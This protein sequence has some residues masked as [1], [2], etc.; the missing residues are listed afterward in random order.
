MSHRLKVVFNRSAGLERVMSIQPLTDSLKEILGDQRQRVADLSSIP[1][2]VDP[3][4]EFSRLKQTVIDRIGDLNSIAI[5]TI[6][7]MRHKV[8]VLTA[9][10]TQVDVVDLAAYRNGAHVTFVIDP[11]TVSQKPTDVLEHVSGVFQRSKAL[12]ASAKS[13]NRDL[14]VTLIFFFLL[15]AIGV[16]GVVFPLMQQ[17]MGTD[18]AP[19][20]LVAMVW[21]TIIGSAIS[22][23]AGSAS[24]T[25]FQGRLQR[26][27]P[28]LNMLVVAALL[29]ILGRYI[30]VN[31]I[32]DFELFD[33]LSP[34]W[35]KAIR[36]LSNIGA[37]VALFC[38]EFGAGRCLAYAWMRQSQK[39]DLPVLQEIIG[40][41][42]AWHIARL[43][44]QQAES[45]STQAIN[46]TDV[47]KASARIL[48]DEVDK[49]LQPH[50]DIVGEVAR[51][52]DIGFVGS[53]RD[54]SDVDYL[55]T[56]LILCTDARDELLR[57]AGLTPP[58]SGSAPAPK[59]PAVPPA[60]SSIPVLNH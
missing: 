34:A 53:K 46:I 36:L 9:E 38:V 13:A 51:E 48:A 60:P 22:L 8:L 59:P 2:P 28:W 57:L 30:G 45:S 25:F 43:A 23:L 27:K 11:K 6:S 16:A 19:S 33:S 10:V 20:D 17:A 41:I 7:T 24:I 15:F 12:I 1:V 42:D 29:F 4:S 35:Q 54:L 32:Q 58:P 14:A 39:G 26:L 56:Q 47:T 3:E 21:F 55:R 44:L 31:L 5:A 37:A 18:K 40:Q 50:H 49:H 52:K